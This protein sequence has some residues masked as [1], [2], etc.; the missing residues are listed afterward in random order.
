MDLLKLPVFA[1]FM[2]PVIPDSCR[3]FF[4]FPIVHG[5]WMGNELRSAA[6]L[7]RDH[8]EEGE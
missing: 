8:K 5:K 7:Q 1:I 2:V 3:F 4:W 6:S